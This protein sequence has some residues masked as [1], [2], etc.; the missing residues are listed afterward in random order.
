MNILYCSC[1]CS[2]EVFQELFEKSQNKPGQQVQKY[3][4]TLL[5]GF[6]LQNNLDIQGISKL[7]I[8]RDNCHKIW[9]YR[10]KEL[11]NKINLSYLPCLNLRYISN[12]FQLLASFLYTWRLIVK[13]TIV[14]LDVLNV[15]MGLGVSFACK[16]RGTRLIG[17]VTDLPEQLVEDENSKFVRQCKKVINRCQGYVLLTEAMNDSVNSQ[18]RKPFVVIE[19][20][21]D[22]NMKYINNNLSD[23]YEKKVCMYT[24]SLNKIHG[25][26]YLVEGFIKADI[27]NAELHIY[28]DGDYIPELNIIEQKNKNIK[29]F[30]VKLNSEVIRAQMKA[31]LLINPRPTTQEFVKYSFPSKNMEYMASGT[32][33]LT[34]QLPGMP[35]EY[36]P[37][38]YIL[39]EENAEGMAIALK[40]ILAKEREELHSKGLEAKKFVLTKK[41]EAIQAQK[42][43]KMLKDNK[44][45]R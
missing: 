30:G 8:N 35:L 17:I 28:G 2:E 18:R 15:S 33:V 9:I 44:F 36:L 4:R 11:W 5:R 45:K 1:V 7:P 42:I 29:Y 19:G 13:D 27:E 20:Q 10:K 22:S 39:Q 6:A 41:T 38:V 24:G 26:Q 14:C 37:Y 21:V 31:T 12:V 32:P 16:L 40:C 43:I 23:K 3:N 34:T 25:I